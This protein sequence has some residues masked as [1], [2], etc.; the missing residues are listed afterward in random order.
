MAD[1]PIHVALLRVITI[2]LYPANQGAS[3]AQGQGRGMRF[4]GCR[5]AA[6]TWPRILQVAGK[7]TIF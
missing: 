6:F 3:L 2:S 7:Q 5:N 1:P 4:V